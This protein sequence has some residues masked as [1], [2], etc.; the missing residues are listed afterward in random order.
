M[1]LLDRAGFDRSWPPVADEAPL[2]EPPY[3]VPLDRCLSE[4]V[5]TA[6]GV[7]LPV[8]ADADV[9]APVLDRVALVRL[10][11]PG[12][13]DGRIFTQARALRERFGFTGEIVV[14]GPVLPDQAA[15]LARCGVSTVVLPPGADPAPWHRALDRFPVAYQPSVA[16]EPV[17]GGFK[18]LRN[19][20]DLPPNVD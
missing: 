10:T 6:F 18:R 11:P 9:L 4:P 13:R 7:T 2:P 16:Q 12:F 17:L 8:D 15:F 20:A 3:L 19:V 5:A 14:D 1:R